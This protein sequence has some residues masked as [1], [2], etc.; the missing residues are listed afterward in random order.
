MEKL[1]DGL[2]WKL[3]VG[4]IF[5]EQYSN[6]KKVLKLSPKQYTFFQTE[7]QYFGHIVFAEGNKT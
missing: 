1:L 4:N 6:F 3:I 2:T 7:V 5:K